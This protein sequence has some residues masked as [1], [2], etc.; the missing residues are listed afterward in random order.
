MCENSIYAFVH[1]Q[2]ALPILGRY[3]MPLLVHAELPQPLFEQPSGSP[4]VY[5]TYL[6]SRPPEWYVLSCVSCASFISQSS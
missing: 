1:L 6:K 3:E 5:E 4:Q 2:T